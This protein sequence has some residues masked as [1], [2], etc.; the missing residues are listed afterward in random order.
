MCTPAS[1]RSHV[2]TSEIIC[3]RRFRSHAHI[4]LRATRPLG[5]VSCCTCNRRGVVITFM[6]LCTHRHSKPY[7][8]SCC[9]ADTG[10]FLGMGWAGVGWGNNVHVPVHT[11]AQQPYHLS[12]SP[13]SSSSHG[14]ISKF[15]SSAKNHGVGI[16]RA[17][18]VM[19]KPPLQEMMW[20]SLRYVL[21]SHTPRCHEA[22]PYAEGFKYPMHTSP[23]QQ[24]FP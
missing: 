14:D 24:I 13:A 3:A 12:Y 1:P 4:Y 8:L 11:Q 20:A 17:D 19:N 10:T 16:G 22:R 15:P 6:F 9:P 18:L 23:N 21:P 2:H 7:H 5:F